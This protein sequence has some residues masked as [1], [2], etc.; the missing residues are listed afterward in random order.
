MRKRVEL[1]FTAEQPRSGNATAERN[2]LE[3]SPPIRAKV[4]FVK[5][6]KSVKKTAF[7]RGLLYRMFTDDANEATVIDDRV[8]SQNFE[9]IMYGIKT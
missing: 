1:I 3:G 5:N 9:A 4:F 6:K 8:G 2:P 7:I